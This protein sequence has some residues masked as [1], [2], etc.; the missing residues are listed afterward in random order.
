MIFSHKFILFLLL[1]QKLKFSL[2]RL[3]QAS[4]S[5]HFN[6]SFSVN[7]NETMQL[8]VKPFGGGANFTHMSTVLLSSESSTNV[9]IQLISIQRTKEYTLLNTLKLTYYNK[10][11]GQGRVGGS[12][13]FKA[14]GKKLPPFWAVSTTATLSKKHFI[15][16]QGFNNRPKQP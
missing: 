14:S 11:G 16:A 7:F 8:I 15:A 3:T 1:F 5:C 10:L 9:C 6:R 4:F 2:V 13:V 12:W